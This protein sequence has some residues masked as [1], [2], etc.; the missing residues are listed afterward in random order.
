MTRRASILLVLGV[1]VL[2]VLVLTAAGAGGA[3]AWH[4]FV[5]PSLGF[6]LSYPAGW[7]ARS[8]QGIVGVSL[9]GPE[10]PGS[11]GLHINVNVVTET[12]PQEGNLDLI[13]SIAER[14]VSLILS[15]YRRLRSDRTTLGG[16][17]AIL[18]Y[19]T[20]RRNDG[21]EIYQMQLFTYASQRA[22]VVTGTTLA[23]SPSIAQDAGLLQRVVTTF[24]IRR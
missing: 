8:Q 9:V 5:H 1:L 22:Y 7:D 13:E 24:R 4:Q 15:G 12:L 6:S 23:T 21:L 20:W 10:I 18:R 16:R 11:N 2:G 3:E 14:Q 17:P 19:F